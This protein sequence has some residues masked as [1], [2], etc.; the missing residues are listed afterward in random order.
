MYWLSVILP[1]YNGARFLATALQS[2]ADQ[3]DPHI[4]VILVDDGSIDDTF[5]CI[6]SF[7]SALALKTYHLSHQGNWVANTNFGIQKAL[8]KYV[9]VLH[10]DDAWVKGR[11]DSVKKTIENHPDTEVILHP[12]IYIG[13]NGKPIGKLKT[14][15]RSSGLLSNST[16]VR[17]LL[18]QDFFSIAAPIW[19]RKLLLDEGP[20]NAELRYSADWDLWL[21]LAKKS[22]VYY[23]HE[24]LVYFRLHPQSQTLSYTSDAIDYYSQQLRVLETHCAP[25]SAP[26]KIA[27]FS[28]LVNTSLAQLFH[29]KKWKWKEIGHSFLKLSFL[30]KLD[31]L[32]HSRLWDRIHGRLRAYFFSRIPSK[33]YPN[34][35]IGKI[36]WSGVRHP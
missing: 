10:Q 30:E 17:T 33:I 7:H 24:P 3:A 8:G 32:T 11:I 21:R 35:V 13:E 26:W 4:E 1:T 9:C 5:Q 19:K 34:A 29:G 6:S 31:Y 23:L 20:F 18:I 28:I 16:L 27:Q 2:I 12:T 36:Y 22:K 14:P 25:G 15:F